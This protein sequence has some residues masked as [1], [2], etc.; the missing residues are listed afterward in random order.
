[1]SHFTPVHVQVVSSNSVPVEGAFLTFE[2]SSTPLPEMSLLTNPQGKVRMALPA[3]TFRLVAQKGDS[4]GTVDFQ[5]EQTT[6]SHNLTII[7]QEDNR[8]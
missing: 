2:T 1:M 4:R 7:L 3:G 5:I 6:V 8:G